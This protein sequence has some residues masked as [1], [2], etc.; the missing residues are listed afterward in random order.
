MKESALRYE[1]LKMKSV[2]MRK[3][4]MQQLSYIYFK[5]VSGDHGP[6]LVLFFTFVIFSFV[7]TSIIHFIMLS[8]YNTYNF[9]Y[10]LFVTNSIVKIRKSFIL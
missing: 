10:N 7:Q 8:I 2:Q 1:I 3:L 9:F 6:F 5:A 4:Q